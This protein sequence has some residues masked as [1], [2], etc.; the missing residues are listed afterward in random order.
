MILSSFVLLQM[1]LV[2]L[3]RH[4][5]GELRCSATAPVSLV[6]PIQCTYLQNKLMQI[7]QN[8]LSQIFGIVQSDIV[9]YLQVHKKHF[10]PVIRL[11]A[12]ESSEEYRKFSSLALVNNLKLKR[13]THQHMGTKLTLGKVK[14]RG[15]RI[16]SRLSNA[17]TKA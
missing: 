12:L 16:G 7:L 15:K 17:L 2:S 14:S 4:S 10:G 9:L 6:I 11:R 1:H 5:S 8:I 13:S 3:P